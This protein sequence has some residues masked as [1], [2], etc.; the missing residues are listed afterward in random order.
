MSAFKIIVC[1]ADVTDLSFV[2]EIITDRDG[3]LKKKIFTTT[4]LHASPH[5]IWTP[6]GYGYGTLTT[7]FRCFRIPDFLL[8]EITFSTIQKLNLTLINPPFLSAT[9]FFRKWLLYSSCTAVL[10]HNLVPKISPPTPHQSEKSGET[11]GTTRALLTRNNF[12]TLPKSFRNDF[13]SA[14]DKFIPS[15]Y[16]SIALFN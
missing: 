13:H 9:W 14:N 3:K 6:A 4:L 16:I 15:S 8:R 2:G 7:D 10:L 1:V 11:L 5:T 12:S